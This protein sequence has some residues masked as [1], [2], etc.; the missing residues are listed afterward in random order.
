MRKPAISRPTFS[1][2]LADGESIF[3]MDFNFFGLNLADTPSIKHRPDLDHPILSCLTAYL[4]SYIMQKMA[5]GHAE[6][7]GCETR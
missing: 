4:S 7:C 3:P 1:K 5:S 2:C 6:R